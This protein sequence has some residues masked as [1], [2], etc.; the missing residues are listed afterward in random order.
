[1]SRRATRVT[2][3]VPDKGAEI[4]CDESDVVIALL[5][6]IHDT[7]LAQLAAFAVVERDLVSH[8]WGVGD[9]PSAELRRRAVV[10][11]IACAGDGGR[12]ARM[13]RTADDRDDA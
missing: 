12:L 13:R 5:I 1:M 2:F 7:R 9:V 3:V 11:G 4:G 8:R 10:G 6:D